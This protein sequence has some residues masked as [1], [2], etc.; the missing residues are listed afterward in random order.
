MPRPAGRI[1]VFAL[2]IGLFACGFHLRGEAH[3][4]FATLFLN[5]APALPLSTELKR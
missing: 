3:Y 1:A 5:P 2:S 4:A